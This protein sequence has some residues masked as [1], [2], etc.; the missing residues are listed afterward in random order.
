[1]ITTYYE[2]MFLASLVLSMIYSFMWHK[3]YSIYISLLFAFIPI[4][5][6]GFL[7]TA[8]AETE[9]AALLGVKI[10]Y[11][12]GCYMIMFTMLSIFSICK[13]R[14]PKWLST[15]FMLQ[16]SVVYLGALSI[17]KNE[18]FYKSWVFDDT[19]IP[20]T[21]LITH[22]QY[23]I[24]HT[25]FIVFTIMYFAICVVTL[26]YAY[27]VK[28][29]FSASLLLRM[30]MP[31]LVCMVSFFYGRVLISTI[32]LLPMAYVFAQ[33]MYLII[34]HRVC[35]YDITDTGIDSLVESGDTGFISF[36][37]KCNFLGSNE[38]AEKI[39]PEL[40]GLTVDERI[41]SKKLNELFLPW[42]EAFKA[43]ENDDKHTYKLNDKFYLIDVNYLF[44]GKKKKGYQIFISDD[45]ANQKLIAVLENYNED[46]EK[47][48][49]E[50]TADIQQKAANLL[51]MH[52]R[53]ILSMAAMV[54]SRDNSTGGHIKRTSEVVKL[55]MNEIMK[56]NFLGLT[57]DFC[58]NI[59]KAAPMHD[60]GKI[61]VDDKILRKAGKFEPD[62]YAI[63]K[64][65][66]A[67]GA[68]IV[69]QVLEGTEDIDF[70][71]IA[72][73]VAH[74]HHERWDGSGY[75]EGLKGED[76]PIEARIM[77]IADV[78][79]A[80]VSKRVYKD[81]MS[82]SQADNI[83]LEGMGKHFDKQLEKYYVAA[84]PA[85]EE[86]YRKMNEESENVA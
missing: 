79:D 70:H 47:Q 75:P 37:F 16:S 40:K 78:Y 58:R 1:M 5:N 13:F 31:E 76:I 8:M 53:L 35:L 24:G 77:A 54:E 27:F 28:T 72:E 12:G 56:D 63:M 44:S 21:S 6:L 80:L 67:E 49:E 22:K 74:Y 64:T 60:L 3:H 4:S 43:D 18:Y 69:H 42:I 41:T 2:I 15:V 10:S 82:F 20:G 52:N 57:D 71:I 62:E 30:F 23:G 86:Y 55:L 50:K 66:A 11:I 25:L 33:V 38:T 61:A 51:E 73:N 83:I 36:D 59:I 7:F 32:E 85:I 34:T 14:I 17:G 48:V 68:R 65:H 26:I 46:L 9:D 81:A 29:D 39:F 45:T 84:R 19:S